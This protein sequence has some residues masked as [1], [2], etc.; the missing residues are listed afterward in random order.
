MT[1]SQLLLD[2]GTVYTLDDALTTYDAIRF[3]DGLVD[4]VG[5][6]LRSESGQ[7]VETFDLEGCTVLPGFNDA[8]T[9]ILSVG[10]SLHETDLA[11]A[12]NRSE[13]LEALRENAATTDPGEWVLGYE[14]DES[15]WPAGE[16]TYLTRND[17]DSISDKHPIAVRR[18]DG[19][20]VSLNSLGLDAVNFDGV[21]GDIRRDERGKPTGVVVEDAVIRVQETTYPD[22]EKARTVLDL[23]LR[24]AAEHGL[25]SIQD[26]AGMTTPE[27]RGDPAHAA[28]FDAWRDDEL[29]VRLAY[30]VHVDRATELSNLEIASGFGDDRLCLLGVKVFADGAIGSQT[31]KLSG[32][33]SDDPGNDGQ[34]VLD[35]GALTDV[36]ETAA[37]ANQQIATHAIGDEAIG[38]VLDAYEDVLPSYDVPNPRLRIEHAELITDEQIERLNDLGVVMSMQ[39]NFLQWSSRDGLYESRLGAE[40]RRRNNRFGAIVESDVPLAFGSDKMPFD[41]LYGIHHAVNAPHEEQRLSVEAA[42]RAYTHGAAFAEFAENKKGQLK[43]GMLGDAVVLDRDPFDHPDKINEINVIATIVG[44]EIVYRSDS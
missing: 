4:V 28:F 1:G 22:H 13:A 42:I 40:W 11:G 30:Y 2:G 34:W 15:T 3:R 32:E 14:Y 10:M 12:D 35:R 23:A 37:R 16:Q 17:L 20:T 19:H 33:F 39:P 6:D 25:T 38:A 24:Y 9:H 27:G 18:V 31:A 36:F 43:P 26:M 21:E 7:D 41:P 5:D 29:P 8:H 44:G